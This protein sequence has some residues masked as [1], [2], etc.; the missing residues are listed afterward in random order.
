MSNQSEPKPETPNLA[1]STKSVGS[2]IVQTVNARTLHANLGSKRDYTSWVKA[3]IDRARLK[4][5]RDF[6]TA[7]SLSSP[8][9]V[10]S[11]ARSQQI[12]EYHLTVDAAKHIAM[13]ANTD[14]GFEIREYFIEAEKKAKSKSQPEPQTDAEIGT[15]LKMAIRME[16]HDGAAEFE[17][18]LNK[19][20]L[21]TAAH[22]QGIPVEALRRQVGAHVSATMLLDRMRR[23][24]HQHDSPIKDV[25]KWAR[26]AVHAE[27][28]KA[29]V[30]AY[31]RDRTKS[32]PLT[33]EQ[34][35]A[36]ELTHKYGT[37]K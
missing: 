7:E 3:Q 18:I 25:V 11:K 27:D 17:G 32:T 23:G 13:M 26:S 34:I 30:L 5:G 37:T 1:I 22:A 36:H 29:R 2:E 15:A 10:S 28:A 24:E 31:E 19:L 4:D 16:D 6:V 9:L 33:L 8:F 12:I 21:A 20:D 35:V 14:K